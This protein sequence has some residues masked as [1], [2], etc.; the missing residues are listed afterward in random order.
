M[1]QISTYL[2][3]SLELR[4]LQFNV[5][6]VNK[7]YS[8]FPTYMRSSNPCGLGKDHLLSHKGLNKRQ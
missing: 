3:S 1:M 5:T 7:Q 8:E 6:L 2:V 4:P